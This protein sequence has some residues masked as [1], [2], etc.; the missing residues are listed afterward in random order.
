[1]PRLP[2]LE[3]RERI[4]LELGLGDRYHRQL[5]TRRPGADLA[6]DGASSIVR[7]RVLVVVEEHL[8][9]LSLAQAAAVMAP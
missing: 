6:R 1:V 4:G 2:A 7:S 8:L 3:A 5:F 9:E